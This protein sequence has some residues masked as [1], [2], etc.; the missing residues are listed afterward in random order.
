[1]YFFRASK[2][3]LDNIQKTLKQMDTSIKNL[4]TDLTNNRVPQSEDDK[5]LDVME[6]VMDLF[7]LIS[8]K[9]TIL[10]FSEICRRCP[11]TM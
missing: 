2:V 5:F 10:Y 9:I 6:V 7:R 11:R 1:M 3:S 8:G 4:K